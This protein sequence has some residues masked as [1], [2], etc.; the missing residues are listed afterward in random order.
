MINIY[1]T[2]PC[3]PTRSVPLYIAIQPSAS[4]WSNYTSD[5][6]R[7]ELIYDGPAP[8]FSSW[9][10]IRSVPCLSPTLTNDY[11]ELLL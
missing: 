1:Y 7:L 11:P 8:Y 6:N 3:P 5:P 2:P 10:Y 9:T 4:R